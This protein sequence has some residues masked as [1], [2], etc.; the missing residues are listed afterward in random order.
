MAGTGTDFRT[1]RWE[2][3]P[4]RHREALAGAGLDNWNTIR[5]CC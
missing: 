3:V 1:R 5:A 4:E 2:Q